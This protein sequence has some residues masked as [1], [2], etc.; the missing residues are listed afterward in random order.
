[1][2]LQSV[3]APLD[4]DGGERWGAVIRETYGASSY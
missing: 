1:V 4:F 3:S 2:S